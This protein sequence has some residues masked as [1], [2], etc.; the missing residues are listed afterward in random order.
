LVFE[1]KIQYSLAI[2]EG[3]ALWPIMA[4]D[5]AE[6]RERGEENTHGI[7]FKDADDAVNLIK[8]KRFTLPAAADTLTKNTWETFR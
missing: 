4:W 7:I 5:F 3:N 1:K 2:L 8:R 6:K